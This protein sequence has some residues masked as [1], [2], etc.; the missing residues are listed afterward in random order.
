[1]L[2][3]KQKSINESEGRTE[4]REG[5]ERKKNEQREYRRMHDGN[6]RKIHVTADNY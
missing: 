6:I 1:M 3:V 4:R 5:K 2:N